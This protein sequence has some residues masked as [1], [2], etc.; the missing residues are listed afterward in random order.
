MHCT[1]EINAKSHMLSH[2]LKEQFTTYGCWDL[3]QFW[4]FDCNDKA[5]AGKRIQAR[6]KKILYRLNKSRAAQLFV[7]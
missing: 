3:Y 1:M 7:F 4:C 6:K 2:I 5:A